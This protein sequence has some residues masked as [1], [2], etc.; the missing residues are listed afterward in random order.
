TLASLFQQEG[1]DTSFIYGGESQFDNMRGFFLNNGFDRVIDEKD[2]KDPVFYGTW[3]VSDE[4]L[5]NR[6]D[7]EFKAEDKPFFALVFTSSNHPPHEFPSGR[8]TPEPGEENKIGNAVR[9]ADYA[10][11]RFFEQAQNSSYWE[12]TLFL[13]VADH[14]DVQAGPD[15]VPVEHFHIPALIMGGRIEPQIISR[16]SS[17]IDLGPTLFSLMGIEA[18]IP[19]PGIDLLNPPKGVSGRAIL[20]YGTIHAMMRDNKIAVLQPSKPG[21]VFDYK[22]GHLV[23][24]DNQ[25]QELLRDTIATAHWPSL[26]YKALSYHPGST[27]PHLVSSKQPPDCK[28]NI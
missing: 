21:I 2:Y 25:D 17:Q 23:A 6:A 7:S 20:Q 4:D 3:G 22:N 27:K 8:I 19:M 14:D 11:G 1:Y 12:N 28:S 9:Y 15:L 10:I 16:T 26:A 5:F 18:D 13:V 24:T